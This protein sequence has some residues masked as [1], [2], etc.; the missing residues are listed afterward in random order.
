MAIHPTLRGEKQEWQPPG[1]EGRGGG[2]LGGG[3][4]LFPASSF[5]FSAAPSSH[6]AK[7]V[8]H[9]HLLALGPAASSDLGGPASP[10]ASRSPTRGGW[11]WEPLAWANVVGHNFRRCPSCHIGGRAHHTHGAQPHYPRQLKGFGRY[12]ETEHIFKNFHF[13]VCPLIRGC[14]GGQ[15]G[16]GTPG[17]G[18]R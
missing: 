14:P 2:G 7:N 17:L 6:L 12:K 10:A 1:G 18:G 16:T 13:G 4:A 15:A 8:P 11:V 5:P 9:S 3:E